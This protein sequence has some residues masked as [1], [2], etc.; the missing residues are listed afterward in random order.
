MDDHLKAMRASIWAL[1][2]PEGEK[3]KLWAD[4]KTTQ[5]IH[6]T[7]TQKRHF[8]EVQ[9]ERQR[10]YHARLRAQARGEPVPSW[11]QPKKTGRPLKE[12]VIPWKG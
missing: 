5:G 6:K 12:S 8:L 9:R 2:I 3:R 1:D 7:D 4:Y 10:R 11:A